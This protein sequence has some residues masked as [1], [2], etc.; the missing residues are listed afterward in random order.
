MTPQTPDEIPHAFAAA[1]NANDA[2][3]IASL[4]D[5]DAEFVNVVGLWWHNRE[6][7]RSAHAIALESYFRDADVEIGRTK[8]RMLSDG[9]ALVH[10][11]WTMGG[12]VDTDGD[13]ASRR[14]G[15][16]TMVA[17]LRPQGWIVVAAHNTDVVPGAESILAEGASRRGVRYRRD[18]AND[19]S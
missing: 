14:S 13:E 15:V 12:Q 1:W 5:E 11:R 8:V 19:S 9:I 16:F 7:I 4:F 18:D 2:D 17:E 3:A 10:W 6:R